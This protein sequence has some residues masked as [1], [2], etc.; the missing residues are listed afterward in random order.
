MTGFDWNPHLREGEELIWQGRPPQSLFKSEPLSHQA[1]LVS[2]VVGLLWIAMI[3]QGWPDGGASASIVI[4][5]MVMLAVQITVGRLVVDYVRRA[6]TSYALSNR[7]ALIACTTLLPRLRSVE[8]T[9]GLE[10][11][12]RDGHPVSLTFGNRGPRLGV[13]FADVSQGF[14][15]LR[16]FFLGDDGSFAFR[17]IPDARDVADLAERTKRARTA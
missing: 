9:P 12:Q 13:G 15:I 4:I 10:V 7:R 17:A 11:R 1:M 14:A 5:P 6:G 2:C 3:A 8:L 16:L